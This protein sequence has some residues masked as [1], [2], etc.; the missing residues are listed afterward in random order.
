[1][2]IA[3]ALLLALAVPAGA[4]TGSGLRGVVTRGPTSPVCRAGEPC[5]APAAKVTL[6]FSR[7]GRVAAR[8]TTDPTGHYRVVLRAGTYAVRSPAVSGGIGS[9]KP[10]SAVVPVGR[11]AI[12]NFAIDTGIR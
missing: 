8:A 2:A 11:V 9:L 12:R 10:S 4:T 6:V 5:S 3:F 7:G 1:M